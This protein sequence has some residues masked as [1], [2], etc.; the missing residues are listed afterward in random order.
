MTQLDLVVTGGIVVT[1]DVLARLDIGIA[2]GKVVL[3][4]SASHHPHAEKQIDAT[5]KLVLP[6]AIDT[7]VHFRDP[8]FPEREDFGSGTRAAAA[9]GVTTV[10]DMPNTVPTVV[11]AETLK[12]KA[13]S[14]MK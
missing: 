7:H 10:V 4:G 2:E 6:G 1:S 11:E 14:C 13:E 9:G 5:G 12:R 8:G 3:L